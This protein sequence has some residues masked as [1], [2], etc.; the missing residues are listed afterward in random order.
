M[1]RK[2]ILVF[3]T[4]SKAF[5][6][7]LKIS[8]A[9]ACTGLPD[10]MPSNQQPYT[11]VSAPTNVDDALEVLKNDFENFEKH[12]KTV[13]D[14]TVI[15]AQLTNEFLKIFVYTADNCKRS[16]I[17]DIDTVVTD[18][19]LGCVTIKCKA[20]KRCFE[21]TIDNGRKLGYDIYVGSYDIKETELI[22]KKFVESLKQYCKLRQAAVSSN[23]QQ[24]A[25]TSAQALSIL[26]E[27]IPKYNPVSYKKIVVTGDTVAFRYGINNVTYAH[28]ILKQDLK[29]ASYVIDQASGDLIIT[30]KD[31]KNKFYADYFKANQP[32]FTF[33]TSTNGD[34][35]KLAQLL[36][37]FVAAL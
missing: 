19:D 8:S 33:S 34:V 15:S 31:G 14:G 32:S 12:L 7:S 13:S 4:V 37:E 22:T 28:N 6:L 18:T 24:V 17:E 16:N 25:I 3:A 1:I 5:A 27:F 21:S 29:A 26:N 23:K 2:Y 30:C 35:K 10:N 11:T 36:N 9:F 20:N